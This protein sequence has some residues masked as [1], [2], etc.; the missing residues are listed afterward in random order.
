MQLNIPEE[1]IQSKWNPKEEDRPAKLIDQLNWLSNIG[2]SD[3]DVILK[4]Y[5]FAVF[6]GRRNSV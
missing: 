2:F 6:G 4:Y 3:V 1:E 5:N